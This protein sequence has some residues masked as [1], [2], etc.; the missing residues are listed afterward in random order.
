MFVS[1]YIDTAMGLSLERSKDADDITCIA[2]LTPR[3]QLTSFGR[4]VIP[5]AGSSEMRRRLG[6]VVRSTGGLATAN[7]MR[8]ASSL[9]RRSAMNINE[10]Y[11]AHQATLMRG[12]A[13]LC[14]MARSLEFG[15]AALIAGRISA[16]QAGL[17]AAAACAWSVAQFSA[18]ER[19]LSGHHQRKD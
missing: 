5:N 7:D 6:R 3:N 4:A 1:L 19:S 15:T 11:A 13:S 2:S 8:G 18:A 9:P 10:E 14:P 12:D 16:F 17:G